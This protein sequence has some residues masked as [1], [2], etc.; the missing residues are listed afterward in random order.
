MRLAGG[1][2]PTHR[3]PLRLLAQVTLPAAVRRVRVL[4]LRARHFPARFGGSLA[5]ALLAALMF[6]LAG[7]PAHAQTVVW[8]ATL[9]SADNWA[10]GSTYTYDGY[11]S[12]ALGSITTTQGSLSPDSF[13][14]G[15]TIHTVELLGVREGTD[16]RLYLIT[17]TAVTKSDLAGYAM[18]FTV[19]GSTTT[20]KVSDAT[21]ETSL[22]FY[23]ADSR[24]SF[25][26]DDWQAK[27]ITVKLLLTVPGAPTGL[28]VTEGHHAVQL[29]W[30]APADNGGSPIT[31][32]EYTRSG[33]P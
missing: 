1:R 6:L 2:T 25:G 20:L 31:G 17:D 8:N 19:D 9:T 7:A 14:V 12:S 33:E 21:N 4:F 18:E 10:L 22:G 29:D 24:H 5:A 3:N 15:T 28:T 16:N 30:T 32:Y 23:W 27:T 11:G 26:P 13:T